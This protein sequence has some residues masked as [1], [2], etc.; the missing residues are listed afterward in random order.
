MPGCSIKQCGARKSKNRPN[1]TLHSL[2]KNEV[3]RR[4][5]LNAIGQE[6]INPRHTNVRV[7]SLHFE[8]TEFNRTLD[9]IR[10]RDGAVPTLFNVPQMPNPVPVLGTHGNIPEEQIGGLSQEIL[11]P[12]YEMHGMETSTRHAVQQAV[13]ETSAA[14]VLTH[15]MKT[16]TRHVVQQAVQAVPGT[17]AS[18]VL[19]HGMETSTRH[20]V[21]QAVQAVPGTSAAP[22]LTHGMET[23]TRHAVQQ[24]VQAVPGTSAAPVLMSQAS[25]VKKL[26][27]KCESQKKS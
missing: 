24:A 12:S 9:L 19:T 16:S 2:P 26:E 3:R 13:P 6:N 25:K 5:W 14:P 21:Q 23:S 4:Q 22:V 15:G 20:A 7:Y 17:S 1:L 27:E 10:L 8:E 18:P 11:T